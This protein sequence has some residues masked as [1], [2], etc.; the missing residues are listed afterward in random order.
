MGYLHIENLY[1][2]QDIMFFK[3]C[4]ALE[5]IHGTSAH[6]RWN[7]NGL[8]FFSGAAPHENFKLLFDE[9]SL[10]E[11]LTPNN[12]EIVI[13]GEAYGGKMQG[14]SDTYGKE[15]KFIAFDVLIN[16]CWLE[17]PRAE[18]FCK[19]F[20]V[21]F[22]NYAIIE[23]TIES[24]NE[25]RDRESIVAIKNGMGG[26]KKREGIVC[27]PLIE[28]VKKNGARIICK[29]KS[30]NFKETKTLRSLNPEDLKILEDAQA[31]AD[32]WVTD[33]RL[34]HVLDK[35]PVD[36]NMESMKDILTAM[37]EDILR[38]GAG[39]IVFSQQAMKSI[40]RKTAAMF[41]K[42]LKL[43]LGEKP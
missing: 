3:H 7:K 37:Q 36:V 11:K 19:S 28:L 22:V 34:T 2:N 5:K 21:D 29:H 32:E 27:R 35:F 41:K 1:K 14:M 23:T 18:E 12:S 16:H 39:E 42:R 6:I 26:G 24:L 4:Y 30:E 38:E 33:M 8:G 20:N 25:Q 10:I 40:G 13:Y 31:I 9:R 43:S 15:L 17:V